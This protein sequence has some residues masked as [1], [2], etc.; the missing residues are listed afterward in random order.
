MSAITAIR[1]APPLQILEL[2]GS[3]CLPQDV[4]ER[5]GGNILFA[6]QATL[7]DLREARSLELV[8]DLT[9]HP[10]RRRP[11][12]F[13]LKAVELRR[14]PVGRRFEINV[15]ASRRLSSASST[16][17]PRLAMS[18]SGACATHHSPYSCMPTVTWRFTVF[19]DTRG[20]VVAIPAI[21]LLSPHPSMG[22]AVAVW[23]M[24]SCPT[25]RTAGSRR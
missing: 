15:N 6:G 3:A 11:R 14:L 12:G 22:G 19:A 18:T 2:V 1:I 17:L 16:D 7:T 8:G 13:H 20:S 4:A 10:L 9:A 23:T 21:H 24:L 5:S 25:K